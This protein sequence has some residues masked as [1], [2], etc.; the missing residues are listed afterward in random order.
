MH[1]RALDCF[2]SAHKISFASVMAFCC[3]FGIGQRTM[4]GIRFGHWDKMS[5]V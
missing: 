3:L 1:F 2:A 5:S 4:G